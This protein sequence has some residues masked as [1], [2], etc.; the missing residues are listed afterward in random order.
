MIHGAQRENPPRPPL[1]STLRGAGLDELP[2]GLEELLVLLQLVLT[3]ASDLTTPEEDH[4]GASSARAL[5][6]MDHDLL[7]YESQQWVGLTGGYRLVQL[8]PSGSPLCPTLLQR[9]PP[10]SASRLS[11]RDRSQAEEPI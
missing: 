11:V 9:P 6:A 8:L 1:G 5:Q 4:R 7:S 10:Q 3:T 2:Q